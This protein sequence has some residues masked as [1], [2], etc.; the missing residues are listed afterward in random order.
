VKRVVGVGDSAEA[1]AA[2]EA[3][4]GK[5]L[6]EPLGR[7]SKGYV[8]V[9]GKDAGTAERICHAVAATARGAKIVTLSMRDDM[10]ASFSAYKEGAAKS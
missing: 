2:A 4:L 1:C 5:L 6:G 8:L 10:K 7:G 9:V 3:R